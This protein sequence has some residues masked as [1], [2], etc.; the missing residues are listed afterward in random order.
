M[1][2]QLNEA[3][4][5]FDEAAARVRDAIDAARAEADE[6]EQHLQAV[7]DGQADTSGQDAAQAAQGD[8]AQPDGSVL[9]PDGT[10]TLPDGS[11]VDANGNVVG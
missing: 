4:A 11:R 6:A 8:V 10:R 9:H 5:A 2:E 1:S 3:L 7:V